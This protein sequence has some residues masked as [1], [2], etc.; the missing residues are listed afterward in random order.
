MVLPGILFENANLNEDNLALDQDQFHHFIHVMRLNSGDVIHVSNG[1]GVTCTGTLSISKKTAT[2]VLDPETIVI[3]K[4]PPTICLAVGIA[5]DTAFENLL[6]QTT[7]LGVSFII[8]V[9]FKYSTVPEKIFETRRSRFEKIL[10][11][12]CEQCRTPFRPTL[13]PVCNFSDLALMTQYAH[14]IVFYEN[15][16]TVF[17]SWVKT[18]ANGEN[19]VEQNS[20]IIVVIG[21]EGGIA[22]EEITSLESAD[23]IPL[24]FQSNILRVDTAAAAAI[25]LLRNLQIRI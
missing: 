6:R 21:P 23:F 2:V 11:S 16:N 20:D 22:P 9:I 15:A 8:P 14:R 10:N 5:K 24:L 18:L 13:G 12:A 3:H 25:T 7:E 1:N 4:K 17:S 19:R